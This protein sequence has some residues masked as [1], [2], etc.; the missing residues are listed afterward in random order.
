MS[1][2]LYDGFEAHLAEWALAQPDLRAIVV[3]G[4]RSGTNPSPDAFADLNLVLFD[5]QAAGR[6]AKPDWL[7]GLGDLLLAIPGKTGRC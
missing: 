2:P 5:R 4:S 7:A 6:G 1:S 3:V